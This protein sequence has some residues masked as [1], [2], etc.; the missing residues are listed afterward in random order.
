MY[1]DLQKKQTQTCPYS[2]QS[3]IRKESCFMGHLEAP[4]NTF[5]NWMSI[6]KNE[7]NSFNLLLYLASNLLYFSVILTVMQS[8]LVPLFFFRL[9]SVS[10]EID[11]T[12][13]HKSADFLDAVF[14]KYGNSKFNMTSEEFNI[15]LEHLGIGKNLTKSHG[16][17]GK[18][19]QGKVIG[20]RT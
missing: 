18:T 19:L 4:M 12:R 3:P 8:L 7:S 1:L 2:P 15:F 17:S 11:N 9:I 5:C 14:K 6:Q 13:V 16:V 20:V 10:S